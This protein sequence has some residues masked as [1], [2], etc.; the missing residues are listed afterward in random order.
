MSWLVLTLSIELQTNI[1]PHNLKKKKHNKDLVLTYTAKYSIIILM[2][3]F[4][5]FPNINLIT[6]KDSVEWCIKRRLIIRC[7]YSFQPDINLA[8]VYVQRTEVKFACPWQAVA[9][10]NYSCPISVSLF[11]WGRAVQV[12]SRCVANW[13][14]ASLY[15]L[16]LIH[17]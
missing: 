1:P 14:K 10:G 5:K 3:D 4:I 8:K 6:I 9:L 17:I 11:R 2:K 13:T 15:Y 16:S 7:S 12:V